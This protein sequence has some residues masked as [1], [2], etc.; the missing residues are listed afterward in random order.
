MQNTYIG[1]NVT[2][3][4]VIIDKNAVI[5]DKKSL[6]GCAELPYFVPKGFTL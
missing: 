5:R 6:T 4:G 1:E 3:N 2:L